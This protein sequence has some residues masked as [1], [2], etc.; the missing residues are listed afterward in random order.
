MNTLTTVLL[1]WILQQ[2]ES[3]GLEIRPNPCD[4]RICIIQSE[5]LYDN[6]NISQGAPLIWGGDEATW[7]NRIKSIA[8]YSTPDFTHTCGGVILDSWNVL[9]AAHC[10]DS[11]GLGYITVGE[12]ELGYTS[13]WFK[14]VHTVKHASFP[15]MKGNWVTG[16][17]RDRWDNDICLLHL[18][19]PITE[20]RDV[21]FALLASRRPDPGT[22]VT[23]QGWGRYNDWG[24]EDILRTVDVQVQSREAC[25]DRVSVYN[26]DVMLCCFVLDRD[27]DACNGDSGGPLFLPRTQEVVGLVSFGSSE[28]GNYGG[29]TLI[30]AFLDW[31]RRNKCLP[32]E[33]EADPGCYQ[34]VSY[35]RAV[36]QSREACSDRVSVYNHDIMLCCFVLDR[37]RDACNGD[38]GGPLFLQRTQEV[39]GLV[40]FGSSECGNYGGYTLIPA[41]LDWVRRNKCL[42]P[43]EEADPG[44]Y[45]PVSYYRAVVTSPKPRWTSSSVA[46]NTAIDAGGSRDSG[47]VKAYSPSSKTRNSLTG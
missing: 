17:W 14:I 40:S 25:S 38:S 28:C 31:V 27:R 2:A 3:V 23:V 6:V 44:C 9:T 19:D 7:D 15:P 20:T 33:E 43:E 41:F 26:H 37:D 1:F 39:V 35:Y 24:K 12:L 18:S 16:Y 22:T 42:P 8:R 30:P 29:Y 47:I 10:C 21:R 4:D 5:F 45:Q 32:P 34:P 13:D 46:V 36:V 11:G